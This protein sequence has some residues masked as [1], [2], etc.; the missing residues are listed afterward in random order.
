MMKRYFIVAT[1]T[2]MLFDLTGCAVYIPSSYESRL[3][4]G[5]ASSFRR[6][7]EALRAKD[8]ER[9]ADQF[10]T[11]AGSGHPRAL[12]AYGKLFAKGQGVERDPVRAAALFEDA[13]GKTSPY[14]GQ[15]ALELGL[16]L[17]KGGDGPSGSLAPDEARSNTLLHDALQRGERRAATNLARIYEQ[18]IGVEP[19]PEKAIAYYQ[20]ADPRDAFAARDLAR[21]LKKQGKSD[22][23]IAAAAERAVS[24]FETRAKAGNEKIWVQLADIYSRDEIVQADP[25]RVVGYLENVATPTDTAMQKR[26]AR[27]YSRVGERQKRNRMLRLAAD[28]GDVWAQTQLAR[29]HLQ[30][31]GVDSNGAVGRYYAESAIAKGSEAAMVYLGLAMLRGEP[32][33]KEPLLGESLLRRAHNAGFMRGTTALGTA[34]LNGDVAEQSPG[35]GK[36]LLEAAAE[37]GSAN[38]MSALGFAYLKGRGLPKDQ[39]LATHWI[40]KAAAAGSKRAKSF[41]AKQEQERA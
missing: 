6:G 9:A 16:L 25:D 36:L 15:A 35:E 20:E 34:I 14:K 26:F 3:S 32:V 41:L 12:V 2:F 33:E 17:Q 5:Y 10:E 29:V 38:A 31:K 37:E 39:V 1:A 21:L 27:I 30:P 4:G 40:N 11:A 24:Q 7:S 28:G 22:E 19:D 23:D 13:Y 18:G 8:F